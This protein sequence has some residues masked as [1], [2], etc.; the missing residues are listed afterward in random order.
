MCKIT[1]CK[2]KRYKLSVFAKRRGTS[3]HSL[4]KEEVQAVSPSLS[5]DGFSVSFVYQPELLRDRGPDWRARPDS[6]I[7]TTL[8]AVWSCFPHEKSWDSTRHSVTVFQW[9]SA[10]WSQ[11]QELEKE[12]PTKKGNLPISTINIIFNFN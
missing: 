10:S 1:P 9:K 12:E 11:Q 7:Y 8:A 4:Q 6:L 2:K 3:C 5:R